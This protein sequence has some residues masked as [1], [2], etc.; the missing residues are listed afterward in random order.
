MTMV[1]KNLETECAEFALPEVWAEL[2]TPCTLIAADVVSRNL[3][4][5]ADYCRQHGIAL[6]PHTKTHKSKRIAQTQLDAGAVGLTVAKPG[7]ADVMSVLG[8]EVLVAYPS[9]TPAS[10]KAIVSGAEQGSMIVALD[11]L[12]AVE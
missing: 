12:E 9:V 10:L 7:E 11:S 5:M 1:A 6:R 3:S 2:D 8:A 4:R